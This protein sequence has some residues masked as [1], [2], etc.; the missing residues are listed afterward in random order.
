[1]DI[2]TQTTHGTCVQSN[3][4]GF[5]DFF[6]YRIKADNFTQ[7]EKAQQLLF[8]IFIENVTLETT[9]THRRDRLEF[10]P[11]ADNMLTGLYLTRLTDNDFELF[12]T[13]RIETVRQTQ[14]S[15]GAL[16]TDYLPALHKIPSFLT[17]STHCVTI[18]RMLYGNLFMHC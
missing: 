10:I 1:M 8:T 7:Q 12:G 6:T 9:C 11:G 13:R 18:S 2:K 14:S 3:Y 4:I 15:Q 17:I 16:T 5:V